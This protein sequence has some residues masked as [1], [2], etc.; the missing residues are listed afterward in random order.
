LES[1]ADADCPLLPWGRPLQV[2]RARHEAWEDQAPRRWLLR[3]VVSQ[4]RPSWAGARPRRAWAVPQ[5]WAL[6]QAV[7]DLPLEWAAHLR[8]WVAHLQAEEAPLRV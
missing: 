7:A 4:P 1:P 3:A 2:S 8:A 5:A 6:P